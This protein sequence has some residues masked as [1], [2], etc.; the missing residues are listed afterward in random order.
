MELVGTNKRDIMGSLM[1]CLLPIGEI[2]TGS[3]AWCF[4]SFRPLLLTLH[5][6]IL[7]FPLL[8]FVLPESV[9]W[10]LAK[11]RFDDAKR[12]LRRAAKVNGKTLTDEDLDKLTIVDKEQQI[13]KIPL[14]DMFKS[15]TLLTRCANCCI[16]WLTCVLLYYGLSLN[17][18]ALSDDIYLNFILAALVEFPGSLAVYLLLKR[19]G[20][21]TCLS[22]AFTLCGICCFALIFIDPN[23]TTV[24]V[25]INLIGKFGSTISFAVCYI[26]TTELFP[27]PLRHSLMGICSTFGRIGSILAPQI[28]LL[29]SR[30]K[31]KKILIEIIWNF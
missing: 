21:R 18:V 3:V 1:S 10:L 19:I 13:E 25:T 28:P 29:V 22:L 12:I 15:V 24:T 27:T 30:M 6:P 16:S 5:T 2:I 26:I 4:R 7:I 17:S 9:R 14:K 11:G 8:F 31:I 20:R 23:F